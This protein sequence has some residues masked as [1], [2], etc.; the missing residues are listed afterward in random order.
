MMQMAF[1]ALSWRC[2]PLKDKNSERKM[3]QAAAQPEM[4]RWPEGANSVEEAQKIRRDQ[5]NEK[6]FWSTCCTAT[7]G[8]AALAGAIM[9]PLAL[10]NRSQLS[11]VVVDDEFRQIGPCY[12]DTIYHRPSHRRV[13]CGKDCEKDACFDEYLIEFGWKDD[14]GPMTTPAFPTIVPAD[15]RAQVDFDCKHA[16]QNNHDNAAAQCNT[17]WGNGVNW[18][19]G[20]WLPIPYDDPILGGTLNVTLNY[21]VLSQ[22]YTGK[23]C[24]DCWCTDNGGPC[25]RDPASCQPDGGRTAGARRTWGQ[26][27]RRGAQVDCFVPRNGAEALPQAGGRDIFH[28][29]T[30]SRY[31][32]E[33][34][35]LDIIYAELTQAADDAHGFLVTALVLLPVGLCMCITCCFVNARD[36]KLSPGCQNV[37]GMFCCVKHVGPKPPFSPDP[38]DD[39]LAEASADPSR[40]ATG[41]QMGAATVVPT[42]QGMPVANASP[43]GMP[44]ADAMPMQPAMMPVANAMPMMSAQGSMPVATQVKQ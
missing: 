33:C 32:S 41:V 25:G 19:G 31:N 37:F 18:N 13:G 9:L 5:E 17:A 39:G 26:V 2:P 21:K 20:G 11:S 15:I 30:P 6:C 27:P 14:F 42:S 4:A 38:Y 16:D 43:M 8:A 28:C 12:V 34:V 36:D 22:A 23:R 35:R 10:M 1:G 40:W 29:P 24:D 3:V 7:M 44:V